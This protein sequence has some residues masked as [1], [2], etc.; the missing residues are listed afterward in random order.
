MLS[1]ILYHEID[2]QSDLIFFEVNSCSISDS[3]QILIFP[4]TLENEGIDFLNS[5]NRWIKSLKSLYVIEIYEYYDHQLNWPKIKQKQ[6]ELEPRKRPGCTVWNWLCPCA[7]C[8][9]IAPSRLPVASDGELVRVDPETQYSECRV[10]GVMSYKI[11]VMCWS[12]GAWREIRRCMRLM[13]TAMHGLWYYRL[14]FVFGLKVIY[15]RIYLIGFIATIIEWSKM[16]AFW[17]LSYIFGCLQNY[18]G[19]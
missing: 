10:I 19:V 12:V 18:T 7:F 13:D 11:D 17:L 2:E 9:I 16:N 5:S 8:L 1:F 15:D 4:W 6:T 3:W 14:E